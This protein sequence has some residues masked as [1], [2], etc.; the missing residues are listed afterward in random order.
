MCPRVS[1]NYND[2]YKSEYRKKLIEPANIYSLDEEIADKAIELR[3]KRMIKLADAVIASTALLNN[4]I[5]ATRNVDNFKGVK[6]LQIINPFAEED[7]D[8]VY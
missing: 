8:E 4:L 3:T 2:T 1:G 5:P 6:Q 7:R